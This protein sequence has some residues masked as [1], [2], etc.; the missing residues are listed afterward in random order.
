MNKID[1]NEPYEEYVFEC[2]GNDMS[3][4]DF[5]TWYEAYWDTWEGE[6]DE[7]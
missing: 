6:N 7:K 4:V 5:D 2:L 3:P 1:V